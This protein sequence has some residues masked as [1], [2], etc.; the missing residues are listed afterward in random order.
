MNILHL[1]MFGDPAGASFLLHETL[2]K[3]GHKSR[4]LIPAERHLHLI[5]Q[6]R[7]I[8]LNNKLRD[9]DKI[10]LAADIIHVNQELIDKN[11]PP[12]TDIINHLK[13]KPFV[14][15]NHGGFNLLNPDVHINKMKKLVKKDFLMLVCSPLTKLIMPDSIWM[16][17]I[18]PIHDQLYLPIKRHY[19]NDV[20]ICHKIFSAQTRLYKGTDIIEE[21]ITVFLMEKWGFPIEFRIFQDTP[22]Q[23]VL[24]QS[25][26]FHICIDNLTQGFIGLSG[27]ESLSKGQVVIAR[28]H[29]VVEEYYNR[30]GEGT[31]PIIN[32]SG[33]DEMCKVIR[34]L[35]EDRALLKKKCEDS[36]RW[37]EKY[38]QPKQIMKLYIN[39]YKKVIKE[40]KKKKKKNE[41]YTNK[42]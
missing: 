12:N 6:G 20:K 35:C 32:V 11:Y 16:P 7:D 40:S 23:K 22:I 36:R 17:N 14:F 24:K 41:S 2:N 4:H 38:Y 29:P 9:L 18:I 34:K 33:M 31:Q 10:F 8:I 30:L 42:T 25:A 27:W 15:H 19:E 21:M 3:H 1:N 13:N 28:L 5:Q 37:M 26:E 39:I